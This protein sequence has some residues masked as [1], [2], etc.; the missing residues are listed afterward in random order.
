MTPEQSRRQQEEALE[1]GEVYRDAE[2][3]RTTDPDAAAAHAESEAD[4]NAEH[5][6]RG[7]VGPGIPGK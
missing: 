5:L 4:R 6:Q 7:E 1:S 3:R 2:G